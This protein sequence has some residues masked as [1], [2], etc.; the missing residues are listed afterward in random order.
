MPPRSRYRRLGQC[1][2]SGVYPRYTPGSPALAH[3]GPGTRRPAWFT[4]GLP[5]SGDDPPLRENRHH[6]PL[7]QSPQRGPCGRQ[8]AAVAT[9]RNAAEHTADRPTSP[10]VEELLGD[11][12]PEDPTARR[13]QEHRVNR[14][15]VVGDQNRRPMLGQRSELFR[16]QTIPIRTKK[17]MRGPS[18]RSLP[19]PPHRRS[20]GHQDPG[21]REQ[22][23]RQD[24]NDKRTGH[25]YGNSM[26]TAFS[27]RFRQRGSF[28]LPF[29][30]AHR[31]SVHSPGQARRRKKTAR[32]SPQWRDYGITL[33][34]YS[35]ISGASRIE[36]CST[37]VD[38]P[39]RLEWP[40]DQSVAELTDLQLVAGSKLAPLNTLTVDPCSIG[41]LQVADVDPLAH[42]GDAAMLPRDP[43]GVESDIAPGIAAHQNQGAI[44][45]DVRASIERL[46]AR[47]AIIDPRQ[48]SPCPPNGRAVR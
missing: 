7:L 43:G 22:G 31:A 35:E 13:L 8:V 18:R 27:G 30:T 38:C 26:F 10:V 42:Q 33:F 24:K 15:G 34:P 4:Q 36:T 1:R 5:R 20:P 16:I 19:A 11:Q 32:R 37:H 25:R 39:D 28:P 46:Q 9:H 29:N 14:R 41:T 23:E 17:R 44:E 2:A 12:E 48:R 47:A 3:A 21:C 45:G 6:P 40:D